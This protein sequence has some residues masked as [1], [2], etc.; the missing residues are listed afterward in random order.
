[1]EV[2]KKVWQEL[3]EICRV[4]NRNVVKVLMGPLHESQLKVAPAFYR[5]QVYLFGPFDSYD[6][7]N[8]RQSIKIWFVVFCC[9][10]TSTIDIR[11]LNRNVVK[12]LMGPLHE[13]QLKVAPAFY[14]SQVYLFGPFDSYDNTNKRQSIKIWFVVFCCI[15]TSTIDIR[16]MED[17]STESFLIP[18]TRFACR[19]GYQNSCYLMKEVS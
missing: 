7:T 8:K 17:Y 10:I 3:H 18:F 11:V 16:V 15:I 6:N 2:S 19:V 13:S 4:L 1:M 14:R 5:S 12:V 9:I